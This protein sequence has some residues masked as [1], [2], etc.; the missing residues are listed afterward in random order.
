MKRFLVMLSLIMFML[1]FIP[2]IA[3]AADATYNVSVEQSEWQKKPDGGYYISKTFYVDKT[4]NGY[5]YLELVET[6]N[7]EI[8]VGSEVAG[9][10]FELLSVTPSDNGVIYLLKAKDG[11]TVNGKTEA[12]T[13]L[14]NITDPNTTQDPKCELDYNPLG[15]SCATVGEYHFDNNGNSVSEELQQQACEGVGTPTTPDTDVPDSPKT[16][17][18][19]PYIAIGGGL[20][21]I[22]GVYLYSRKSNKVYKI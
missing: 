9:S 7:V 11:V 8:T 14:A 20:I 1:V 18:V 13:V 6:Y 22:A 12:L 3:R 5:V 10:S 21:A 16:G 15:L 17:S 2:T 19:V 4:V